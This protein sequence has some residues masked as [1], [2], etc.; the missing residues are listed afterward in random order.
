MFARTAADSQ[1]NAS[2]AEVRAVAEFL[3][4]YDPGKQLFCKRGTSALEGLHR[5]LRRVFN[6]FAVSV[7]EGGAAILD[8]MWPRARARRWPPSRWKA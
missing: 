8:C 5:A 6:G 3:M 1:G 4:S 2:A 7:R